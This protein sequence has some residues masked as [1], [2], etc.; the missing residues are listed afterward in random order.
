M[1]DLSEKELEQMRKL[2]RLRKQIQLIL[3]NHIILLSVTFVLFLAGLLAFIYMR[4]SRS[5]HRY[6]TRIS[7]HYYPKQPGKIRPYDEKFLLQ[8]FNRPALRKK[9]YNALENREFVDL[10]PTGPVSVKVEKKRNGSFAAVLYAK[11]DEEAVAFTN[12]FAQ[13][14]L[15][16]YIEKRTSDLNRWVDVLQQKKQDV[17]KQIQAINEEKEKLTA[18]LQVISPEKDYDRLRLSL[19]DHQAAS[20]KLKFVIA[21]L[22]G[23]QK[24]LLGSLKQINPMLLDHKKEIQDQVAELKQL[25]REINVVRELYTEENP[26]MIALLSRKKFRTE[27]LEATLKS[28]GLTLNDIKMLDAADKLSTELNTVLSELETKEEELRVLDGEI[29]ARQ[30]DFDTLL[31]ILPRYQELEQ[32]TLSLRDSLQKLDESIADINYLLLLVKDDLFITEQAVTAIGQSPFRKKNLAVAVF[33]A[34]SLTGLMAVLLVLLEFLFGKIDYEQEMSLYPDLRYLGKLP[35]SKK[36]IGSEVSRDLVFT[37]V[38]HHFQTESENCHIILAG[39]LPGGHLLQDFFEACEWHQFMAGKKLLTVDVILAC[40]AD[41]SLP[42]EDTGIVSYSGGK[43][44]LPVSSTKYLSPSEQELLKQDLTV[45]R[46]QYDLIFFRHSASFRHDR[47]FLEQFATL[48]DAMLVAAGLKKTLR[49]YMRLLAGLQRSTSLP[50]MTL[51]T[52]DDPNHF[53]KILNQED[54]P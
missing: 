36:Q 12:A 19:A 27:A 35:A 43:G 45:L 1:E 26:K 5:S 22:K 4:V 28:F 11:T 37:T 42:M 53:T 6:V 52:D 41:D 2:D 44:I 8:L 18:P 24:R 3:Q 31:K 17:F 50:V 14:C 40:N 51:L 33:A 49:K 39:T 34:V 13:Q 21:N 54:K 9:F 38:C 20:G 48:C 25:D 46:K 23:R 47:L 15:Q 32:H 30:K 10:R 16:E 7:L 29:A